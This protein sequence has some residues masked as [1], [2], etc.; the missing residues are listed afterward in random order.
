MKQNIINIISNTFFI[1]LV[2]FA[3]VFLFIPKGLF[4]KYKIKLVSN[5]IISEN[6]FI[7]YEDLDCDGTSEIIRRYIDPN[8]M[9]AL[10]VYLLDWT[11]VDQFNIGRKAVLFHKLFAF[12]RDSNGYKEIYTLSHTNDSIFLNW[13]EPLNESDN[14]PH[15]IFVTTMSYNRYGNIDYA[16]RSFEIADLNNDGFNEILFT[17]NGGYSKFPRK[18]YAY[19][20]VNDTLFS[21]PF[22]GAKCFL[23]DIE[24]VNNDGFLEV[25][26]NTSANANIHPNDTVL[27]D[28]HSYLM[29]LDHQLNFLFKPVP[30]YG[31]PSS[32]RAFAEK[33][34]DQWVLCGFFS[35]AGKNGESQKLFQ[36]DVNG[37][38]IRHIEL[39]GKRSALKRSK[40]D[41]L[42]YVLLFRENKTVKFFDCDLNEKY[43]TD[44]PIL[45]DEQMDLDGDGY[46]E[47]VD[48]SINK[49]LFSLRFNTIGTTK[50]Y[51]TS[52]NNKRKF[53]GKAQSIWNPL[54][55]YNGKITRWSIKIICDERE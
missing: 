12:D 1:A 41:S 15:S 25:V 23:S 6:S 32:V 43:S 24:D 22:T 36:Y 7:F 52:T 10:N 9:N 21:S 50:W 49:K 14:F 20:F 48:Y 39:P 38:E 44:I 30:F 47:W 55:F 29:V 26:L 34:D 27:D 18:V 46:Y 13:V 51:N 42:V 53:V 17:I 8:G 16:G 45:A 37:N 4:Q 31:Y 28:E 35:L 2:L 40:T 11:I 3:I 54:C 19:D 33:K 5:S